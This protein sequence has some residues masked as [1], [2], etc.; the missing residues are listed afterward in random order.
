VK[1]F[2]LLLFVFSCSGAYAQTAQDTTV[3][4]TVFN[5]NA[6]HKDG[7]EA[8]GKIIDIPADA[9]AK[10][11]KKKVRITGLNIAGVK[12]TDKEARETQG[13]FERL[14]DGTIMYSGAGF[15]VLSVSAWNKKKRT[16]ELVYKKQ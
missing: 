12:V 2:I 4:E 8:G 13:R 16:W 7:Y 5:K 10:M 15:Y 14:P 1:Y 3:I 9:A 6:V 11:D